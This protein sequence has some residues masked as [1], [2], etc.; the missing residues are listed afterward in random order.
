MSESTLSPAGLRAKLQQLL[1]Q[2]PPVQ[3]ADERLHQ[4]EHDVLQSLKERLEALDTPGEL[5]GPPESLG[6]LLDVSLDQSQ[7]QA[8]TMLVRQILAGVS[9][10]EARI[11]A[12][13]SD[14]SAF[15]ML[16]LYCGGR[17]SRGQVL[18]RYSNIGRAAGVQCTDMTAYYLHRLFQQG[19]VLAT[20]FEEA[21][22]T[23]YELLE[24]DSSFR[25]AMAQLKQHWPKIKP[26]R[27]T[28]RFSP[29]GNQLWGQLMAVAD[30]EEE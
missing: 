5:A 25:K 27:E 12:A 4:V 13:L 18:Y 23:D 24:G 11:L 29:L 20:G 2:L 1:L 21:K 30:G 8:Q 6:Q 7:A 19:W 15:P 16:S 22:R 10:D 14:G 9:A 26:Q 17:F 28:L 3:R